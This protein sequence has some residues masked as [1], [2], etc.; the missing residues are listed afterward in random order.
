MGSHRDNRAERVSLP[1]GM[2]LVVPP[3]P[4]EEREG[5]RSAEAAGRT[6]RIGPFP[7]LVGGGSP[8]SEGDRPD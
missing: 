2:E 4:R 1:A 5:G 6:S 3:P 7:P 8:R